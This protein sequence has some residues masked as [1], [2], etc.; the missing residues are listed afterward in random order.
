MFERNATRDVTFKH[1]TD[2]CRTKTILV[3]AGPSLSEITLRLRFSRL[4]LPEYVRFDGN[5]DLNLQEAQDPL[6][7]IATALNMKDLMK[8]NLSRHAWGR[9][10]E[11][12]EG[13][14]A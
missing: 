12:K 3:P 1:G 14:M 9:T 2:N 7:A 8:V 11:P 6:E 4:M 10:K 5:I 13:E